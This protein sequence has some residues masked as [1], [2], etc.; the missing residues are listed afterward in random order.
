MRFLTMCLSYALHISSRNARARVSFDDLS[1]GGIGSH[2]VFNRSYFKEY[3]VD[4]EYEVMFSK[5][6]LTALKALKVP[7]GD[8]MSVEV[9]KEK[10]LMMFK[11]KSFS[12]NSM[13]SWIDRSEDQEKANYGFSMTRIPFR[14]H[15]V[16]GIGVLP[17]DP[18]RPIF[19]QFSVN[20]SD[21]KKV[22]KSEYI[23]LRVSKDEEVFLDLYHGGSL[24]KKI[25]PV[26][27]KDLSKPYQW[28]IKFKTFKDLLSCF[29]D[30]VW[31][32]TYGLFV[33]FTQI[34]Q[35]YSLMYLTSIVDG[36]EVE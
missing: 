22:P 2:C 20:S 25:V 6:M 29:S 35:D 1:L 23:T 17:V 14:L 24:H 31:I 19:A 10:R 5:D 12:Y 3:N 9:D 8:F 30:E 4:E 36:G 32:T 18:T 28:T 33:F 34:A 11:G 21:L 27:L 16:T 7:S 13:F 26:Q 15:E